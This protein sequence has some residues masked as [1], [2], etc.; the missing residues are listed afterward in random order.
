MKI[1]YRLHS[2][3]KC[4]GTKVVLAIED[5]TIVGSRLYALIGAN[6][7]GKSTLLHIL[8]FLSL[9]N[10][11]EIFYAGR[12][13]GRD[14]GSMKECR[15]KVTLLHQSPYLFGGTVYD[16]VAFGLKA[17]GIPAEER[18]PIVEQALDTVGLRGFGGRKAQEL[19]GGETQR[20]AMA[21]ALSLKPEVLL[22]DEPLANIDR[23]TTGVLETVIASLPS[24]GT[25]VIMTTHNPEHPD[26]LNGESILLEGGKA[27][28]P[29][30]PARR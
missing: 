15:R 11:G 26:R 9:P 10:S 4:Y 2:V 12:R 27:T 20:V 14:H 24:Q 3:R 30:P 23:E 22:L 18:E 1:L 6:G 16:N 8:A 25:T 21:R 5:L 7:A 29:H 13:V 28:L 19:S 17:R